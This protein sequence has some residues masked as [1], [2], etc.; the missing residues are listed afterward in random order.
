MQKE[1]ERDNLHKTIWKIAEDLRGSVDGWDF[2]SYVL[3]FLFY[4]F[5]CENLCAYLKESHGV[6][7]YSAID[8]ATALT[9]KDTLIDAK[10][11]FISPSEL[12]ETIRMRANLGEN[13]ENL[14]QS[15]SLAFKNIES[16]C[17]GKPR[18]ISGTF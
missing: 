4:R 2:K 13:L 12:F 1:Q 7:D 17:I 15:L 18:A 6:E 3:G 8:E 5:I 16:S 10:G 11:F 14:N 9:G